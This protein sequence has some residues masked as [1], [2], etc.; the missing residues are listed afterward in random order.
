M[1]SAGCGDPEPHVRSQLLDGAIV[2]AAFFGGRHQ[3]GPEVACTGDA[4][5]D[6]RVSERCRHFTA[7]STTHR[8]P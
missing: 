7:S 4:R 3:V 6:R 2:G 1:V 5:Q 8:R